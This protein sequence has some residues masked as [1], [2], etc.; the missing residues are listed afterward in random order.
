MDRQKYQMSVL[1]EKKYWLKDVFIHYS[2]YDS[3][4]SSWYYMA[5]QIVGAKR[6]MLFIAEGIWLK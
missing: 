2:I 6:L 3:G 1:N 5:M 4:D